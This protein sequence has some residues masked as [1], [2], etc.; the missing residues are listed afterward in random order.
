MKSIALSAGVILAGTWSL[1]RN[2]QLPVGPNRRHWGP[3]VFGHRGCRFVEGI[4]ENTLEAF[5]FAVKNGAQGIECDVRLTRDNK[6][7]VFHDPVL[8]DSMRG[9]TDPKVEVGHMDYVDLR[10]LRFVADV[11]D[12]GMCIPTLDATI[13]FCRDNNLRLLIDLKELRRPKQ[14]VDRLLKLYQR[15]GDYMYKETMVIS[16]DPRLLYRIRRADP[17][18]AVGMLHTERMFQNVCEMPHEKHLVPRWIQLMPRLV[19]RGLGFFNTKIAPWLI[20]VS[21]MCPSAT[22]YNAEY[23]RL[24]KKRSMS[25]YLWGFNKPE[26]CSPEM[27]ADGVFVSADADFDAYKPDKKE[28]TYASLFPDAPS[29]IAARQLAENA[30]A[31][32]LSLE[33]Y[34]EADRPSQ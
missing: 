25:V 11:H 22:D 24:W 21:S 23:G 5:E 26:E 29:T 16:F 13:E 7:V 3:A 33:S 6:I 12:K 31:P 10:Q 1:M 9:V 8:G 28:V 19:D 2:M 4:P 32:K 27:R 15:Y 17:K 20:G 34:D 30:S 14:C 18:I